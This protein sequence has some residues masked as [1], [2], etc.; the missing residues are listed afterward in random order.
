[1]IWRIVLNKNIGGSLVDKPKVMV[2]EY[3]GKESLKDIYMQILKQEF[4]K[5]YEEKMRGWKK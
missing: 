3:Y 2:Q 4:I 1:M 5:E